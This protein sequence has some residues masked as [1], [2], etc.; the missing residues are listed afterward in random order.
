MSNDVVDMEHITDDTKSK[1][2]DFDEQEA[3]FM[4]C[5]IFANA[6]A[7]KDY[8]RFQSD[9][10]NWKK[11]FP[12]DLFSEDLKKKIKYM[13]SKEFLETILKD[14][15]A[16]DEL[17]KKDPSVGLEK[18]HKILDRAEKNKDRKLL[19]KDLDSLY[20]EYPL[21]FLKDKYP[22]LV[23]MLISKTHINK[24]LEKFDSAD[25]YKELTKITEHPESFENA[26]E[27][28]TAI[29]EYKKLYPTCDFNDS[30]KSL[31]EKLVSENLED[32]KLLELFPIS[33]LDLKDGEV[34][35]LDGKNNI[36]LFEKDA[37][38]E[39]L[40]I[41]NKDI[42]NIDGLYAWT[43]KYSRYIN[44]FTDGSKNAIVTALSKRYYK[45]LPTTSN[46]HIHSLNDVEENMSIEESMKNIES[47]KK[48]TVLQVLGILSDG[49]TLTDNDFDQIEVN[50]KQSKEIQVASVDFELFNFMES[51]LEDELTFDK[52]T[53]FYLNPVSTSS[54]GGSSITI[55]QS[56][57]TPKTETEPET[58]REHEQES[59]LEREIK[60][61]AKTGN[62]PEQKI[63]LEP[64]PELE[65]QIEPELEPELEPVP[66][67]ETE[68]DAEIQ[69]IVEEPKLK[70]NKGFGKFWEFLNHDI[71]PKRL[72]FEEHKKDFDRDIER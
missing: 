65:H 10:E 34:I 15:I 69:S 52:E 71:T 35:S 70:K 13:L 24:I 9:L 12:I 54:S 31:V 3:Y 21:K 19:D 56:L 2:R 55:E 47:M 48:D 61:L 40:D 60:P 1:L 11:H 51:K 57:E 5:E 18:L 39:F 20:K 22:H 41:A 28:K 53:E 33:E 29:E 7:T 59:G 23:P 17:S 62:E 16:F 66:E 46:Y 25:A 26:N 43:S 72:H 63:E 42:N 50:N 4:L 67:P 38:S 32:K 68:F 58:E 27:Y 8:A 30:Y 36:N 64:V 37:I 6:Q 45:E 14:F 44:T 49:N